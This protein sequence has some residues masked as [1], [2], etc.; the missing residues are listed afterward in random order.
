MSSI[1]P[2]IW[3]ELESALPLVAE[4]GVTS[5]ETITSLSAD[6]LRRAYSDLIIQL[7]PRRQ[8][9]RLKHCLAI[10]AGTATKTKAIA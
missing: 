4:P 8:G 3:L 7:S 9:M 6:T 5:A 2:P 10:V 1:R